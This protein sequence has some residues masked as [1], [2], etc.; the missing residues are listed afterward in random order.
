VIKKFQG[1]EDVVRALVKLPDSHHSGAQFA[2]AGNDSTIRLWTLEGT[3]IAELHG[4]E[5]FI[6]SLA[7]LPSGELVS[8][9]EDRTVRVWNNG[10]C[11]QTITHP[12]ISVWTVAVSK[13]SG[14]I[15]SGASD[16][17]VR[18]FSRIQQRQADEDT[19]RTFDEAVQASSIP[20]QSL[21]D[22]NKTDMPG[23]E[24][25]EQR[26]GTKEGQIQLIKEENGNVSAYQWSTEGNTWI[27]VGTVV[28]SASSATKV[29]YNGKDYDYVFDVDIEDGKPPLKLPYNA[30]E[31]PYEAAR[32]FIEANKLPMTYLDEVTNFIT[33]NTGSASIGT[34]EQTA[35][36]GSDPWG[37]ENRYRPGDSNVPPSPPVQKI[38][39]QKGY[40]TIST[41]NHQMILKKIKEFNELFISEGQKDLVLSE[42]DISTLAAAI[43]KLGPVAGK[44]EASISLPA[45]AIEITLRACTEWP[46]EKRLP[47]L[48]LLRLLVAASSDSITFSSSQ[49]GQDLVTILTNANA[50][51]TDTPENNVM[52]AIRS[53][54]NLFASSEGRTLAD[55]KFE[56]ILALTAAHASSKNKNLSIA[57]TTLYINYAVLFTSPPTSN[58]QEPATPNPDRAL[59][60][61]AA[62][63]DILKAASDPEALYRALV[64]TGTVL[65][66]GRDFADVAREGLEI[67]EAIERAEKIGG[68]ERIKVI[69]KEIRGLLFSTG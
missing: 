5:N 56:D 50:F 65:T 3:P 37:T 30:N 16:K 9:S 12:A 53:F 33:R 68:E 11:V 7:A 17:I 67:E 4:H 31:N 22:I 41:A 48:D 35:G 10:Q 25:L 28:D 1:S 47:W 32:K 39:P 46:V 34:R 45:S 38:L 62:L 21:G 43:S 54:A 69:V 13:E 59:S 8:S 58:S 19:L 42:K 44:Q 36:G 55:T 29:S 2:S 49:P 64:A 14:D 27:N 66:M 40:L 18:V 15:V 6:Y 63:Q 23:P 26:S 51:A 61:L 57:L 24:F 20:S 52:L 60:L